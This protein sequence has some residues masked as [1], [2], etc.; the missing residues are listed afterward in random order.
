MLEKVY[1]IDLG[2]TNSA[3]AIFERGEAKILKN[4][5]DDE[6]TPSVVVFTGVSSDGKD[7]FLVGEQ[8]KNMA[9]AC[10][11]QV[12]QFVKRNMGNHGEIYN[13]TA[14]SGKDYTPEMISS[15]ILRKICKDAEQY[16]GENLVK[17]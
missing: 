9:A 7:E 12:V 2:T 15:L 1:G 13:F 14:P 3:I 11:E 16:D 17:M 8:A 4:M 10:L 5:D 6:V